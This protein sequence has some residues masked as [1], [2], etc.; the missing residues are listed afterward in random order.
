MFTKNN[1]VYASQPTKD[2]EVVDFKIL[3]YMY[4]IISFSNGEQR[5]FDATCLL[6]YPVYQ[7]L[8]DEK[9]FNAVEIRNGTLSWCN[10][11]IDI[12]PEMLYKKSYEYTAPEKICLYF[13]TLQTLFYGRHVPFMAFSDDDE[14]NYSL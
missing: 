7:P 12:A 3:D 14:K 5:V 2:L 6:E 4:M 9:I 11:K 13:S 8:K 10:N 1:I